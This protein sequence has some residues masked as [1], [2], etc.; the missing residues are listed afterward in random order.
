MKEIF[1]ICA[2]AAVFALGYIVMKK[3]D[4][5]L[6][7]IDCQADVEEQANA[8][9][10][11]FDNPLII[12][13]LTPRIEKFSKANPKCRINTFFG[14]AKEIQDNLNGRKVDIGL[15]NENF[16]ID[17]NKYNN[18]LISPEKTVCL[19]FNSELTVK[20]LNS[21]DIR[22]NVVWNKESGNAFADSFADYI[23]NHK[24]F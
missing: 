20:P 6:N 16:K 11:A 10:V 9:S 14:T 18:I 19:S 24:T 1:L 13:A 23:T 21:D 12:E 7:E 4:L 22:I 8:L 3:L 15:I 5:F 2:V 17:E